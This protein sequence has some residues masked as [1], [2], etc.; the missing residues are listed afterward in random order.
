MNDKYKDKFLFFFFQ[1]ETKTA[2]SFLLFSCSLIVLFCHWSPK[3]W[4]NG[5]TCE[6]TIVPMHQY[7]HLHRNGTTASFY[8]YRVLIEKF[9]C[10]WNRKILTRSTFFYFNIKYLQCDITATRLIELFFI[11]ILRHQHLFWHFLAFPQNLFFWG[12]AH[13][14]SFVPLISLCYS[15]FTIQPA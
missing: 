6:G 14:S 12:L 5:G 9:A 15:R 3:Q 4:D 7:K 10:W 1:G 8:C 13:S 11:N 2:K